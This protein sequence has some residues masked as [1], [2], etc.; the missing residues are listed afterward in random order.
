MRKILFAIFSVFGFLIIRKIQNSSSVSKQV[1]LRLNEDLIKQIEQTADTIGVPANVIGAIVVV[2][3]GGDVLSVGAVGER[4]LM[5][6]TEIALNDI[7]ANEG[8][9]F[10][11]D[12]MFSPIQNLAAGSLFIRLQLKRLGDMSAAIRAYNCGQAGAIGGCGFG[13]L[14]RVKVWL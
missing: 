8:T 4:G 9:N 14:A 10:N 5:Q 2:E 1:K 6:L 12:Q 7:N 13:Y 11:F 3:S